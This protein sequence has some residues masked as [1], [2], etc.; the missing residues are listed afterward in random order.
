LP[1]IL[2]ATNPGFDLVIAPGGIKE[3][4]TPT[5][6]EATYYFLGYRYEI[7]GGTQTETLIGPFGVGALVLSIFLVIGIGLAI[8]SYYTLKSKNVIKIRDQSKA[9]EQEFASALFQLGNRLGDGLP[10][11]IA[12]SKVAAVME[13]T[14]SGRFFQTVSDN[15]SK[16]GMN[17]EQAI[18]DEKFGALVYYPSNLIESSMKVLVESSKKGPLVASQA[19]IN[20][21]E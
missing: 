3:I 15:I 14:L 8:G 4:S 6:P 21:S 16:R 5:V 11:E 20:V 13:G 10:A 19:L 2:H 9:L 12:F 7:V 17:V 18:F 1:L